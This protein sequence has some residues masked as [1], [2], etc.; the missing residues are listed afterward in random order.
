MTKTKKGFFN[1]SVNFTGLQFT[2]FIVLFALVSSLL[3][4]S[5][6]ASRAPAGTCSY[7]NGVVSAKGLPNDTVINFFV[8]NKITGVQRG[9]VLG[10]THDTTWDVNVEIPKEQTSYDFVSR[11]YGKSGAKYNIFAECSATF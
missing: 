5:T 9:W 7:N 6:F 1:S 4:F 10:I 11:T 8:T 2:I 3:I